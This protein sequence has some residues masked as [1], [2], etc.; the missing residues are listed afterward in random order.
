MRI[1]YIVFL[2]IFLFLSVFS[3]LSFSALNTG[4]GSGSMTPPSI[5]FKEWR[6][7]RGVKGYSLSVPIH[8]TFITST[9]TSC[10]VSASVG[11]NS[12]QPQNTDPINPD[13]VSWSFSA[14]Q[15]IKLDEDSIS[16][17]W[18]GPHPSKLSGYT[19]FNVVAELDVPRHDDTSQYPNPN[20]TP[21]IC[22]DAGNAERHNRT[23]R[24]RGGTPMTITIGF[25][26][27]TTQ[28][29]TVTKSLE[30][31]QDEIDQIRQE[32]L[33]LA[34]QIPGR[35]SFDP[36]DF[37]DFGHYAQMINEDLQGKHDAWV[38][39]INKR[40]RQNLPDLTRY[41]LVV[42]SGYRNPHHNVYHSGGTAVH[43]LHQY[44]LALDVRGMNI[45]G[46][47]GNDQE[48]MRQ[49]A[50]N[51][52]P[53]ARRAFLYST[54]HVHADW[55]D[56]SWPPKNPIPPA[57]TFTLPAQSTDPSLVLPPAPSPN[58]T[59]TPNPAMEACGVHAAGT[60]G[61]HVSYTCNTP[62]CNNR[63]YWG[64]VYTQCPETSSHGMGTMHVCG[65]HATSVSGDHSFQATCSV[66]NSYGDNCSMASF[67]ACQSHTHQY[68]TRV[69]CRRGACNEMLLSRD[70]H[71]VTCMHGHLYWSCN[72]HQME[73][74]KT[75]ICTRKKV[76]QQKWIKQ[77]NRYQ[78]VW[79]VC[80]EP[81]ARCRWR[82]CENIYGEVQ[83]HQD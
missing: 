72:T 5:I 58:P 10:S 74:H 76:V 60:S 45:D 82:R 25:T 73:L 13:T 42:T 59:P 50:L 38:T 46:E 78:A 20:T 71:R 11:Y 54:G 28:G 48:K 6:V 40:E 41:Q 24:H 65:V 14:N 56:D 70:D 62:P 29:K 37:Y 64:C 52:D 79:G 27:Q 34:R 8:R 19:S 32:Y 57:P 43:G 33:D 51:A 68:P 69:K 12:N 44:G 55:R 63:V 17:S 77:K 30:L 36:E 23:P 1:K 83:K 3:T 35:G 53:P 75:R 9:Q 22:T 66:T 80:N 15:G 21:A 18:S 67:Y 16:T 81:W 47:D 2:S 31:N 26:A 39:A 4:S 61:Y 49:A 7:G